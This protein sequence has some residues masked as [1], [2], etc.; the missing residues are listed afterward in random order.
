[1]LEVRWSRLS[2]RQS[3]ALCMVVTLVP[4][5]LAAGLGYFVLHRT[6]V[7]DYRDVARRQ[8]ELLLPIRRLQLQILQLEIPLEEHLA[9]GADAPLARFRGMRRE[10]EAAYA[11]LAPSLQDEVGALV[12]R[13][14]MDWDGLDQLVVEML[15][16]RQAGNASTMQENQARFDS[17]QAAAHD[18]LD[19]ASDIIQRGIDRDYADAERGLERSEWIAGIA[20]GLSLLLMAS[21]IGLFHR[22]I[23]N[24]IDRLIEGAERFS[25][26]D[27]NHRIEVQIPREL[28]LVAE[29]LNRMIGTIRESEDRL[30]AMANRDSL[31]GLLNRA[32]WEENIA[33]ALQR[34]ARLG[35]GF[36][37]LAADLDHFKKINDTYGHH[38]GDDALRTVAGIMRDSVRLIDKVFRLG[39]E[40][41]AILLP[42]TDTAGAVATA[43]RVRQAVEARLF[44]SGGHG[45]RATISLGV[46]VATAGIDATQLMKQADQSLYK[47]KSGGRNRVVMHSPGED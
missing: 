1:M 36:A 16:G 41:F 24:S 18:R 9:S 42:A 35:E 3:L 45:F 17:L 46:A 33:E 38:A 13:S 34:Q 19:A 21:G 2:L 47:A 27:R 37:L 22:T 15:A 26:G 40:E 12:Q 10:V 8:H 11:T 31:T 29:E 7:R 44:H 28:H 30:V 4:L 5:L 32:T 14:R 23:I 6:V 25:E 43:E 39:G 20:A